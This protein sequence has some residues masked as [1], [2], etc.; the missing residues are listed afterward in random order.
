MTNLTTI[1]FIA[2]LGLVSAGRGS[3][4]PVDNNYKYRPAY[5]Y[6][7]P[8]HPVI[9]KPDYPAKPYIPDVN[10]YTPSPPAYPVSVNP[11]YPAKPY[12]PDI[13]LPGPAIPPYPTI[14]YPEEPTYPTIKYPEE[15]KA[16]P[17][18]T[19]SD[20]P[21]T[22]TTPTPPSVEHPVD[23]KPLPKADTVPAKAS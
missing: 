1:A 2:T 10:P 18:S 8:H 12:V 15:P 7:H 9:V 6:R 13:L 14:K 11:D 23:D 19:H 5:G 17:A 4:A 21:A 22:N 16:Y 20:E 3:Y